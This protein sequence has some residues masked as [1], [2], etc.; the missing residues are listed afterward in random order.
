[1]QGRFIQRAP[2]TINVRLRIQAKGTVGHT[3]P[4]DVTAAALRRVGWRA[5]VTR[6]RDRPRR[7]GL[8]RCVDGRRIHQGSV[9][10]I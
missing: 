3:L 8:G 6:F 7:P 10:E 5:S 4:C 1:V 9:G 2:D